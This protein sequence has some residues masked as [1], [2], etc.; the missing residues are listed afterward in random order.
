[1]EEIERNNA[2]RIGPDIEALDYSKDVIII[3]SD[4]SPF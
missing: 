2:L 3:D 4:K 1:M